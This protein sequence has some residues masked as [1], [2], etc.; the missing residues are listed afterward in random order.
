MSGF[1]KISRNVLGNKSCIHIHFLFYIY[2]V[3]V[4]CLALLWHKSRK[5]DFFIVP[6]CRQ[7][8]ANF[9][10]LSHKLYLYKFTTIFCLP[11]IYY[12]NEF[13]SA[14]YCGSGIGHSP[15]KQQCHPAG[16]FGPPNMQPPNGLPFDVPVTV[17][18][19]TPATKLMHCCSLADAGGGGWIGYRISCYLLRC[20]TS[21]TKN[22][23]IP[24][25]QV[26][27]TF[28]Y[29]TPPTRRACRFPRGTVSISPS[30]TSLLPHDLAPHTLPT[31]LPLH[32]SLRVTFVWCS[33]SKQQ[34]HA[35]GA[36][37]NAANMHPPCPLV[38][39]SLQLELSLIALAHAVSAGDGGGGGG[40]AWHTC[41][42][43]R[44][45][46]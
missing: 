20:P 14:H 22:T 37:A 3:S 33:P 10:D 45:Y 8:C 12:W 11:M 27:T 26:L 32:T 31:L 1:Q 29:P 40:A 42:N 17:H 36:L 43:T 25:Y 35:G 13:N 19:V 44:K 46:F 34:C 21:R 28:R 15:A 9:A 7:K 4:V 30:P 18:S 38:P 2:F 39:T 24:H 5:V 23:R 6:I 41:K 16:W